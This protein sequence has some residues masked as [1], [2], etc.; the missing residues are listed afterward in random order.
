MKRPKYQHLQTTAFHAGD[1]AQLNREYWILRFPARWKAALLKLSERPGQDEPRIPIASLN[2][3]LVALVPDLVCVATYA[4]RGENPIWIVSDVAV[5]PRSIFPVIAAWA[6]SNGWRSPASLEQALAAMSADDLQWERLEADYAAALQRIG[7]ADAQAREQANLLV[8]RLLPHEIAARLSRPGLVCDHGGHQTSAFRRCPTSDGAEIMSWPPHRPADRPF[9]FTVRLSAQTLPLEGG[10]RLYAHLGV[11]RWA[12]RA[13]VLDTR[14]YNSVYINPSVPWIKGVSYSP[15][16]Q[17]ASLRLRIEGDGESTVRRAIWSDA[18]A[19]ILQEL[20]ATGHV[21]FPETIR[22]DPRALLELTAGGAGLVFREGMYSFPGKP[23]GRHPVSPGLALIDRPRILEWL[24]AETAPALRLSD[25]LPRS[26][27]CVLPGVHAPASAKTPDD[28]SSAKLRAAI[29]EAVGS[30]RLRIEIYYDT[31]LTLDHALSAL[32]DQLGVKFGIGDAKPPVSAR[33]DVRTPQLDIALWIQPV[34]A[35]A[36]DLE[37]N[38][39]L[40]KLVERLHQAVQARAERIQAALPGI[41]PGEATIA[42]VEIGG[43]DHYK[44]RRREKDPKFAIRHGFNLAG[45]LTQF[46]QPASGNE[47]GSDDPGSLDDE[48]KGARP[49]ADP[50]TERLN[51]TWQDLWRQLG[52]RGTPIPPPEHGMPAP[53][54]L[55]FYVVRQNQTRAWGTTRQ[56][57]LAVLMNHDGTNIQVRAPGIGGWLPLHQALLAV[58]RAH[59]MGGQIRTPKQVTDFFY[60]ILT[61]DLDTSQPLLLLTAAQNTRPGWQ[62]LN[63]SQFAADSITFGNREPLPIASLPGLR[64]VRVRTDQS[65]ETPEGYGVRDDE[66]GH[67]GAIWQVS[68]RIWFSTADKPPTARQAVRYSSMVEP[69]EKQDGGIRP[70]R[71]SAQVWNHQLIELAVGA[72]QE[73]DD[74]EAWAAIAH[75]LRWAAPH[76]SSPTIYPWPLHLAQL[77][78]EYIVPIKMIEEIENE[79]APETSADSDQAGL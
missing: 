44:G 23:P 35:L 29:R 19:S 50:E 27:I 10:L 3:T 65:N 5:P 74:A 14:T 18:F 39:R 12:H 41:E 21:T 72:I 15:S 7:S 1:L 34:G 49:K 17:R 24:A 4:T 38:P 52:A 48:A 62:F 22:A 40:K 30:P 42:L 70:P 45:R 64:H 47:P 33:A 76:H 73:G 75:D 2:R 58:G 67:A 32:Q 78:G 16:F 13:P 68:D 77:I 20:N 79:S 54:F 57:P 56:V 25:P 60:E 69:V 11:R 28:E 43:K 63:N 66:K 6:R 31:Q 46:L 53:R 51:S 37:P 61:Q 59:V 55:A 26:G 71:P 36:S 9:S 8:F